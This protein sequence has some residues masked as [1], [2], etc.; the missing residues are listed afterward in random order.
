MRCDGNRPACQQCAH[1][2]KPDGC[3]YD[4]GKG[5][6]RTQI[7]RETIQRLEHRVRELEDPEY[8]SPAVILF[9]PH[10]QQSESSS[11][12][13]GSPGSTSI[14]VSH[15]PFPPESTN[16]P[17]ENWLNAPVSPSP[18]PFTTDIF[19]EEPQSYQTPFDLGPMLLDIFSPHRYQCGLGIHMG[20]LRESLSLPASE[21]RH[22]ALMNAIYLWAC[23]VSRPKPL[24]QHE[25]TFLIQ[26]LDSVRDGL[27]QSDR[28]LDVIQASCLLSLYFLANGRL[29]EG[30]FH[31]S[32]V[33]SLAVQCGLQTA[34]TGE[35]TFSPSSSR[36]RLSLDHVEPGY[37]EGERILAFWQVYNLDRCWSVA[38]RKPCVALDSEDPWTSI[39]CPWPQDITEYESGNVAVGST[40]STV[41]SFLQGDIG[42]G[43]SIHTLRAKA[44]AIFSRAD[45]LSASWRYRLSVDAYPEEF[46][47]LELTINRFIP[48]I[49]PIHQLNATLPEEKHT[50]IVVHTLIQVAVLQLYQ[51]FAQ[52]DPVTYDKCSAAAKACATITKYISE[53]DYD[54]LDPIIGSCWTTVAEWLIREIVN[55]ESAWP[56][57]M[58]S[59]DVRNDIAAILYAMNSL[60][61]RFPVLGI[62]VSKIQKKMAEL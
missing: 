4:D 38:L 15:S 58:D 46:R 37:K 26:A 53:Q 35:G 59:S 2:K 9:D 8:V 48:T 24:S 50:L 40:F 52:D 33:A 3:E 56:I 44:S 27:R 23:F 29:V 43:F 5:K 20:H 49:I 12:S 21:Q 41:K 28:L 1:A 14:S 62:A 13:Y 31:A 25:E 57:T 16:S 42:G 47:T 19:F 10:C 34:V 6:T 60:N 17:A 51:R 55:I 30:S 22:P 39:D 61:T 54:Y 45:Q 36:E 32:A 18:S 7:L 11:S